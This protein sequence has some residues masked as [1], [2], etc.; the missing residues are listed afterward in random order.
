MLRFSLLAKM[1][2]LVGGALTK[3]CA[4]PVAMWQAIVWLSEEFWSLLDSSVSAHLKT[5]AQDLKTAL[6]G[7]PPADR[8]AQFYSPIGGS[9]EASQYRR[10]LRTG[11]VDLPGI[12]PNEKVQLA[13]WDRWM[14]EFGP[15]DFPAHP[16]P[17]SRYYTANQQYGVGDAITLH[18][19]IR[20]KRPSRIIEVGC[21]FSS[22]LTLDTLERYHIQSRCIFID[23]P[24]LLRILLKEQDHWPH[25]IDRKIKNIPLS[26]FAELQAGDLLLI[27]STEAVKTGSDVIYEILE[28]LPRLNSGVFVAIHGMIYPFECN[29]DGA[30]NKSLSWDEVCA[31]RAFLTFNSAFQIEFWNSFMERAHPAAFGKAHPAID[32]QP[33]STLWISRL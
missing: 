12:H 2:K 23:Y 5:R 21:G 20:E 18:C 24:Q 16:H 27:S 1:V 30:P 33:C 7:L 13:R 17:A 31:V 9:K 4:V 3:L 11:A 6:I 15:F 25:I 8:P 14:C 22:A 19:M 26:L 32:E 28:I 29:A 10:E